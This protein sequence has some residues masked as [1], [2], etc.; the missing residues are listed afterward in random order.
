M[1]SIGAHKVS[2]N[3]LICLGTESIQ[4]TEKSEVV[5]F[6]IDQKN[7]CKI[8]ESSSYRF[9]WPHKQINNIIYNHGCGLVITSFRGA[10]EIFDSV[11]LYKTVWNNQDGI[12]MGSISAMDYSEE[13]DILAFGTVS[14]MIHFID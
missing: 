11:D 12:S 4:D 14:G 3:L 6:E 10:I 9:S 5:I 8:I 7:D 13:L 1:M 2:G